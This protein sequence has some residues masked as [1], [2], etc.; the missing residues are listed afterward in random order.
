[1]PDEEEI[2]VICGRVA[3]V[4]DPVPGSLIRWCQIC[5]EEIYVAP[6]SLKFIERQEGALRIIC[7]EC[8]SG[9]AETQDVV[10]IKPVPGA[11]RMRDP[12]YREA[13]REARRRWEK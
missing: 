4:D 13:V 1:M 5:A 10:Q 11:E 6:S 2:G 7:H 12:R 9:V 3:D 8:M